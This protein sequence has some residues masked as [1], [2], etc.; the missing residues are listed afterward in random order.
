MVKKVNLA[1]LQT[2]IFHFKPKRHEFISTFVRR[3]VER[4][5]Y[6]DIRVVTSVTRYS[7]TQPLLRLVVGDRFVS[8]LYFLPGFNFTS[9]YLFQNCIVI[10]IYFSAHHS[11]FIVT[12]A[13]S[14]KGTIKKKKIG[15]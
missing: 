3:T 5:K 7:R 12:K 15:G 10:F 6:I 11:L 9:L 13:I 14:I 8:F 4:F 1:Q 2:A